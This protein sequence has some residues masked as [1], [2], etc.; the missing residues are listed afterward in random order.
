MNNEFVEYRINEPSFG[1]STSLAIK[2][3]DG[4]VAESINTSTGETNYFWDGGFE[5]GMLEGKTKEETEE[6]M[7]HWFD[8]FEDDYRR[9]YIA[10]VQLDTKEWTRIKA[11]KIKEDMIWKEKESGWVKSNKRLELKQ[12]NKDILKE[13]EELLNKATRRKKTAQ[14]LSKEEKDKLRLEAYKKFAKENNR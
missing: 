12:K 3:S 11:Q 6:I 13:K 10:Q 7:K 9:P 5:D 8:D 4:K 1:A 2:F 14:R